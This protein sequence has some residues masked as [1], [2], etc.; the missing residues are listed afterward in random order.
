MKGKNI[1]VKFIPGDEWI[2]LKI[3]CGV[4]VADEILSKIIYDFTNNF[5]KT[6][7]INKWFFIRYSDPDN[8][9]RLRCHLVN[10]N[11]F[12]KVLTVFNEKI[13]SLVDSNIIWKISL[14]TYKREFNRYGLNSIDLLEDY[15]FYN[16]ML[17]L[18]IINNCADDI[19]RFKLSLKLVEEIIESFH[20][21]VKEKLSF[22]NELQLKFKTEFFI[23]TETKRE[24]NKKYQLLE[25]DSGF[26]LKNVLNKDYLNQ[27]EQI[28]LKLKMLNQQNVLEVPLENM[29]SNIIH[30][31]I[32]RCFKTKQRLYE[33]VIYDFL[34]KKYKKN[35]IRND[36]KKV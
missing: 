35:L 6:K 4:K 5:M 21:P 36:Y 28:S 24:L 23:N 8:H 3:Y 12:F 27:N 10:K 13:S 11:D 32:N 26:D 18:N 9:L 29:M 30:M 14:N 19:I 1:K 25:I 22:L 15:F 7:I 31:T 17:V 33:M 16:S 34:F 2:Y 20:L